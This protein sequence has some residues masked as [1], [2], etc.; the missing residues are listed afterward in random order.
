MFD[1]DP[2]FA[3]GWS[4]PWQH[5]PRGP[6]GPFGFRG[7]RPFGGPPPMMGPRF[8]RRFG[9]GGPRMFGRGDLK[10]VLL[11]MLRERPMHGYEMIKALEERAGGFYTPS[12]GAIYPTLQLLEDRGWVK[13]QTVDDKKVY[14][15]TDAGR[16][17]LDERSAQE[18]PGFEGGPFWRG[19]HHHHHGP[20][21]NISPELAALG[22]DSMQ[23]VGLLRSAVMRAAGDPAQLAR[24]RAI[25]Q[26]TR[27]ALQAFSNE[28]QQ[29]RGEG[30]VRDI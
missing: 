13:S 2:E 11:E 9:P 20:F 22:E 1:D 15:I 24:L 14:S 23:V 6:R 18:A 26:Q 4:G 28:P 10:F 16:K 5:G 25:I 12:A 19:G 8:W 7:P 3:F 29:P 21:G 27:D 17:A 30:P